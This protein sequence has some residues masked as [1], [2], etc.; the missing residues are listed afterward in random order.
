MATNSLHAALH[1]GWGVH[2]KDHRRLLTI[3]EEHPEFAAEPDHHYGYYAAHLVC[4]FGGRADVSEAIRESF[5]VAATICDHS[6]SLPL[7]LAARWGHCE[8]ARAFFAAYPD[9]AYLKDGENRRPIEYARE[10]GWS[11]IL[12]L[13]EPAEPAYEEWKAENPDLAADSS[14]KPPESPFANGADTMASRLRKWR[15]ESEEILLKDRD[16][17]DREIL[18]KVDEQL[19]IAQKRRQVID[20]LK[21]HDALEGCHL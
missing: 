20:Q 2:F 12:A 4:A 16:S 15:A 21:A 13:L 18:C 3:L 8:P 17:E 7:H 14:K 19:G 10:F 1:D 9:A 5:P 11:D 6:G